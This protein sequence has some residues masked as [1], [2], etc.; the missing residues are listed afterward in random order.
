MFG[1]TRVKD[2]LKYC[3]QYL[4]GITVSHSQ[5][6]KKFSKVLEFKV[7]VIQIILKFDL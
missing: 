2:I 4:F 7:G 5:R 3:R 6:K 1:V